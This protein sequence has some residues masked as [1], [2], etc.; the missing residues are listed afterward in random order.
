MQIYDNSKIYLPLEIIIKGKQTL[1]SLVLIGLFC[2]NQTK[3]NYPL[4]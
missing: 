4:F 1:K 3:F 2:T